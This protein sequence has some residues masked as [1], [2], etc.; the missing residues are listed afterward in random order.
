[1]TPLQSAILDKMIE[2]SLR[3][4]LEMGGDE[5]ELFTDCF[6]PEAVHEVSLY[7][8]ELRDMDLSDLWTLKQEAFERGLSVATALASAKTKGLKVYRVAV[9]PEDYEEQ[10]EYRILW[11]AGKGVRSIAKRLR[12]AY[13]SYR[14]ELRKEL[15]LLPFE[16]FGK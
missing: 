5:T 13:S 10:V 8:D 6:R 15:G 1:M 7:D 12:A 9:D 2:G 16:K 3:E 4:V 14:E 11:F